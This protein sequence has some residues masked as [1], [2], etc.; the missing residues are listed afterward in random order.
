MSVS[1]SLR[2]GF[3]WVLWGRDRSRIRATWRILLGFAVVLGLLLGGSALLGRLAV[4]EVLV[5]GPVVLVVL[6]AVGTYLLVASRLL[7]ERPV[8]E[9]GFEFDRRWW[10]DLLAGIVAGCLLQAT[11]TGLL[12]ALDAGRVVGTLSTGVAAGGGV[13]ALVVAVAATTLAFAAIALWEELLFRAVFILNAS[14]G[15][16][17]RGVAPRRAVW[18]AALVSVFLFGPAHAFVA[19]QGATPLF[20]AGQAMAAAVYFAVGYVLTGS[21]ALPVGMHL[22]TNLWVASVFGQA[23]SGFPALVRLERSLGAGPTELVAVA[24]PTLV[25]IGCIVAWVCLTRGGPSVDDAFA[26]VTASR[27]EPNPADAD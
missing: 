16:A 21:L 17:A 2:E 22:S 23:G 25:G 10:F 6:L 9:Y 15:L 24:I 27:S 18:V 7:G 1:R 13:G 4:P 3:R 26:R 12:L 11:A 19:I 20:A 8:G 5:N 14:E